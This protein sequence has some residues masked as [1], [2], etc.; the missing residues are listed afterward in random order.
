MEEYTYGAKINGVLRKKY[1]YEVIL[2]EEVVLKLTAYLE[3]K[4]K[5]TP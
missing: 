5:R 2:T 1:L 3:E 4:C